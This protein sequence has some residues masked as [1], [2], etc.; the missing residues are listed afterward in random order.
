MLHFCTIRC[1]IE[2]SVGL[3]ATEEEETET[4]LFSDSVFDSTR[5]MFEDDEEEEQEDEDN[6]PIEKEGSMFVQLDLSALDLTH[7]FYQ[8]LPTAGPVSVQYYLRVMVFNDYTDVCTNSQCL[9]L[10]VRLM[11][12]AFLLALAFR[13]ER[14]GT[15]TRSYFTGQQ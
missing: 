3:C 15:P 12:L 6:K 10:L 5:A 2:S 11:R 8:D 9:S 14:H 7:T 13:R 1:L 4:I